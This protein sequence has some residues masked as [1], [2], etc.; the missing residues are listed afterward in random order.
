MTKIQD[1]DQDPTAFKGTGHRDLSTDEARNAKHKRC[2]CST[3][4]AFITCECNTKTDDN[5]KTQATP[6]V[7]TLEKM[8]QE[9]PTMTAISNQQS[10]ISNQQS[11]VSSQ[12]SGI[13]NQQSAVSRQQSAVSNQQSAVS[14]QQTAISSQQSAV[15]NQQ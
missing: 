3:D 14:R 1:L 10:A 6:T 9:A 5:P 15:S 11:A 13:S 7:T 12:Q 2:D 8:I 4:S